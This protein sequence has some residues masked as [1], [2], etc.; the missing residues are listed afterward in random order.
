MA[1]VEFEPT[2]LVFEQAKTFHA[3]DRAATEIGKG[4]AIPVTDRRGP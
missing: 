1:W 4:K 3:F 2:I